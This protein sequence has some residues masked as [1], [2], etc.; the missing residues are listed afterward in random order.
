MAITFVNGWN[1]EN[2]DYRRKYGPYQAY[3]DSITEP[4]VEQALVDAAGHFGSDAAT[5]LFAAARTGNLEV[6][7]GTHQPENRGQGFVLH[8]TAKPV[9]NGPTCHL[10]VG[11][12]NDGT[13]FISRISW[14]A[15]PTRFEDRH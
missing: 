6:R 7:Q 3:L 13:F 10:Y 1:Q 14:G 5:A 12:H 9:P 4:L 2:P 15:G 11:Q 8:L